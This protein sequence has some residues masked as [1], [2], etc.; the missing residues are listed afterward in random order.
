MTRP[1]RI[2]YPGALYHI[3][4]RGN[5][6]NKIFIEDEDRENFLKILAGTV[7]KYD[8]LCYAYCLMDNHYHLL[9]ET[10]CGNL[11]KGMRHLNGIYTQLFN[12]NHNK[13]G[14]VLQGRY[15]AI[16][17]DKDNYLLELSRYIVLNPV[18]AGKVKHAIDY[19]W[20]SYSATVGAS[21]KP[22]FLDYRMILQHFSEEERKARKKYREF[23]SDRIAGGKNPWDE[24]RGQIYLGGK[25]FINSIREL[26]ERNRTVSEIPRVQRNIVS[27]KL[28]EIFSG[29][30]TNKINK[31][32]RIIDSHLKYGYTQKEIADYLKMHYSTVSKIIKKGMR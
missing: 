6:Y 24:L 9:V 3:T 15:K 20:S 13:V 4:S 10:P 1:L 8:W 29:I 2:E 11:S 5:G 25:I 12:S 30:K 17:V 18:R 21:K 19:K 7:S 26:V 16:I 23:V 28:D 31:N 27:P 22:D 32:K 14:H